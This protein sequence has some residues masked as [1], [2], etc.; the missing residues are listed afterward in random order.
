MIQNHSSLSDRQQTASEML[1]QLTTVSSTSDIN[2]Y[3]ALFNKFNLLP[4]LM[5]HT[6]LSASV[7][8]IEKAF[9]TLFTASVNLFKTSIKL[10]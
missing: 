10:T 1:I 4:L 9:I 5:P 7:I 6:V 8:Q 2:N 3:S